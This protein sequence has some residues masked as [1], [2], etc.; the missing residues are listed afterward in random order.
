MNISNAIGFFTFCSQKENNLFYEDLN[1]L[2]THLSCEELLNV[3]KTCSTDLFDC[4]T[5]KILLRLNLER[6]D[7]TQST[8]FKKCSIFDF[9]GKLTEFELFWYFKDQQTF[10]SRSFSCASLTMALVIF[11]LKKKKTMNFPTMYSILQLV[12]SLSRKYFF[13]EYELLVL[14]Q[15]N[16]PCYDTYTYFLVGLKLYSVDF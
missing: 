16:H 8:T 12:Y 14:R 1:F 13:S 11:E 5:L 4:V 10:G 7:F 6:E 9:L 2:T 3:L 15:V